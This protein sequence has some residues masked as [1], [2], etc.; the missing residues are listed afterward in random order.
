MDLYLAAIIQG[1]CYSCL[2]F[3]VYISL[4]IFKIPDITTDGSF[5]IGGA[6]TAVCLLAGINPYLTMLVALI[7]GAIAGM[8][9]GLITT[10]IKINALLAGILVMTSLYSVNLVIMGRSNLTID[11]SSGILSSSF[12]ETTKTILISFLVAILVML[13]IWWMLRTDKG[14][15]MRATGSNEKM[16]AANGINIDQMKIMGLALANGLSALSGYLLVQYQGFADINMGMGIVI[17]GL[18]AVMIGEA[19]TSLFANKNIL[20]VLVSIVFGCILFRLAIAQSLMMGL[21]PNYLKLVTAV[22]VLAFIGLSNF[23]TK[24][25]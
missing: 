25:E 15:A 14:I 1:L 4:R 10:R 12:D 21:N 17:S 2:G 18:A 23:K 11:T 20:M 7:C 9:T 22:I 5:T 24:S 13:S 19:C 6:A 8:I 16:A 3:G